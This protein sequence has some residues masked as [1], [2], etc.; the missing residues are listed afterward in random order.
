M[1]APTGISPSEDDLKGALVALKTANPTLGVPKIHARLV[2]EHPEWIVSE[3]RTRKVLQN[4][5]LVQTLSAS[6]AA[7]GQVHPTS[8]L[9]E[10]L[11]VT[12]WTT[13]AEVK[14]FGK[15]KGKGLVAK[16]AIA[17]GEVIWKEDPFILAPEWN[18]Y[19][20]QMSSHAC[21][22]CSTPLTTSLLI[23]PCSASTSSTPCPVRFCS[24]LC[25]SRSG[26]THPLLCTSRNPAAAPLLH[27]ARKNQWMALHAL[28]QMT[29][30]VLLTFQQDDKLFAEDWEV[31]RSLAQLGMEERA[32]GGWCMRGHRL[33]AEPDRAMW[34]KAHKLY[35]Q[36]F[37]EPATDAEKKRLAKLLKKPLPQDVSDTLFDYEAFLRGLGRMSLNLE[38][39]GG[40]YVLHSH[41]NHNCD[42][43]VSVRHLDQ[44]T[45]LSRITVIARRDIA[46]G[47]ELLVTYVNPELSLEQ[48][49]RGL[50]E[51]GFGKC[52]CERCRKE[53][54]E[55]KESG[56]AEDANEGGDKA[57]L[58]AELKAGL[59]VM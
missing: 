43:N 46:P 33:G 45:A 53:E 5:G 1:T 9:I 19:D 15:A 23:V 17:E 49:R 44:R 10:G 59:G 51:W 7:S 25:L 26:R 22:H 40:L 30:R 29:A 58:E 28:A 8:K 41:L 4:Q 48:R 14:Y 13:K 47:E 31:V 42:P 50:M 52:A 3:K 56:D 2:A 39:H 16:E 18:L 54:K 24:R 38:A 35:V 34:K 55:K 12:K 11:D 57:D 32:K 21:G 37:Q 36:A 6:G 20:L 27:F